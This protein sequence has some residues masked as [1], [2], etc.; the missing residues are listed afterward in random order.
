MWQMV[1]HLAFV[2][3]PKNLT[4]CANFVYVWGPSP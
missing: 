4:R 3:V 1:P 2:L